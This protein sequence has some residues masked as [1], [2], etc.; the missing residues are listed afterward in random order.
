MV[1]C[2]A[3]RQAQC[4][5]ESQMPDGGARFEPYATVPH[6]PRLFLPQT[7]L[8]EWMS[9]DKVDVRE[10]KIFVT[11]EKASYPLIPAVHFTQVV[12]G[13]DTHKLVTRVKTQEQLA[14][15]SAEQLNDSVIVGEAAYE[16]V[17]GYV[18]DVAIPGAGKKGGSEAD[19]LAEFFLNKLG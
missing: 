8:E 12:S 9:Q 19:L 18:T 10:D 5:T 15:L 16:V 6:V 2:R 4:P 11:A 1:A 7:T 13:T 17:P 3:A 14:S